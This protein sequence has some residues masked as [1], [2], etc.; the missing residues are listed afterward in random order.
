MLR[1]IAVAVSCLLVVAGFAV[2]AD[3]KEAQGTVKAV[4]AASVTVTDSAAMDW[5]FVVDKDTLVVAR[6]GSHKMDKLKADGK[7]PSIVEFVS[8]KQKVTVKVRGE[9]RQDDR[10]GGTRQVGDRQGA[11]APSVRA[12]WRATGARPTCARCPVKTPA[13]GPRPVSPECA[14]SP[15]P[16]VPWVPGV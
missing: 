14:G 1:R 7:T 9:R 5:T 2:A 16:G 12:A 8:E 3:T 10:Q 6:G 15:R 4:T 13:N 11:R